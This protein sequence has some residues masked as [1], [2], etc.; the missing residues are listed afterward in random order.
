MSAAAFEFTPERPTKLPNVAQAASEAADVLAHGRLHEAERMYVMVLGREPENFDALHGLGAI[1]LHQARDYE[2]MV[3]LAAALKLKPRSCEALSHYGAALKNLG[4]F[5]EALAALDQALASNPGDATALYE[6]GKVLRRLNRL[7]DALASFDAA[8]A[9]KPDFALAIS[10]RGSVLIDLGRER[11]ALA[12]P[13]RALEIDPRLAEAHCQAAYVHFA[14]GELSSAWMAY[15]SRFRDPE[16]GRY[17]VRPRAYRQPRWNGECSGE[18]LL[19]WG[20][21]GLG[22]EILFASMIPDLAGR[23]GSIVLEID[24]RLQRL[25]ARSFPGVAVIARGPE[26]H[27]GPVD[28]QEPIGSLGRYLR[29]SWD[30]FPRRGYLTADQS[31]AS[32]L[33]RRL[34]E[35]GRRVIG[36]SWFSRSHNSG[37]LRSARLA[38]LA[39]LARSPGIRL[40]DLQYGDTSAEREAVYN[41]LGVRV[42]RIPEVDN[43]NDIDAL[44]A[45]ISACDAVVTTDNTTAHLAGALGAETWVLLP[46][47]SGRSWYWF[48][49]REDCPWY[50]HLHVKQQAR[51]QVWSSLM[52]GVAQDVFCFLNR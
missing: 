16:R 32:A 19:V 2:A 51:G 45:L 24:P 6:R 5:D 9:L 40:I 38:D 28:A 8:I 47:G 50:P 21:Q 4:R 18:R 30:A 46:Y 12:W 14:L 35:D 36:V 1:R 37:R 43:T 15:E 25:F 33:R 7:E 41:V 39:A 26:L 42:E 20:E 22:D 31:L 49:G 34:S 3:L 27:D 11:E 17:G 52:P 13:R 48:R 44:A 29:A 23:V 10:K